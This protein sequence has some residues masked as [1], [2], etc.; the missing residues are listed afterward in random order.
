MFLT[1]LTPLT[2]LPLL[3]FRTLLTLLTFFTLLV[4]LTVL[5]VAVDARLAYGLLRVHADA[6]VGVAEDRERAVINGHG[7][8]SEEEVEQGLALLRQKLVDAVRHVAVPRVVVDGV[9]VGVW[10]RLRVAAVE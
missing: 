3:K 8:L 1:F 7:L 6:V 4:V 10:L 9:G 2:L 5:E